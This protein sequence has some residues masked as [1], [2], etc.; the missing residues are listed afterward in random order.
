MSEAS[1]CQK[2]RELELILLI[3]VAE[4]GQAA[5]TLWPAEAGPSSARAAP[6]FAN[7]VHAIVHAKRDHTVQN[8]RTRDVALRPR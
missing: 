7:I 2:C 5:L 8:H 3:C 6:T 4:P 1:D